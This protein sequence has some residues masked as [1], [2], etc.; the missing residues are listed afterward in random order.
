MLDIQRKILVI[1][2]NKLSRMVLEDEL[3]SSGC[4]VSLAES[5]HKGLELALSLTPDLIT[6]DL[7]L[8]DMSCLELIKRLKSSKKTESIPFVVVT[9]FEDPIQK[10]LCVSAGAVE[11]MYKPFK[12]GKLGGLIKSH[13]DSV[14]R[15]TGR[16]IL[17]VE[18]SNTIR[19]ITKHLL[20]RQGHTVIEA[21]DGAEG[22]EILDKRFAEVDMIVT[23]INMPKM[24][25]RQLV[26]KIRGDQR[27]QFIPVIVSTTIAEKGNVKLL[28]NLGADDYIVKPFSTEEFIARIHSHLRVKSLYEDLGKA[29]RGLT[30]FNETLEKRVEERTIELKEAN[31]GAIY[32]L[33]TAAEAKDDDTGF[34]V[35]RIQY[36]S[37]ALALKLGM[38]PAEADEIGYSSIMHD[39]GKISIPDEILKKP[40]K[41]TTEE[42]E[43]IKTHASQGEKILSEKNFFSTARKIARSHHEKWSGKGY[44][45][46]LSKEN[47]P[48]PA[49]IVAVAD[50]FDALTSKRPYKE[51]WSLEKAIEE[52]ENSLG[53]HFDPVIVKAWLELWKES[54]IERIHKQW[55]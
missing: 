34:H 7:I 25:G 48:L 53:S 26:E 40:G 20:E 39:V 10:E 2:N 44:P 12:Q 51:P 11:V 55:K 28:L 9:G 27:S 31:L 41:L 46:G 3:K 42:F 33:A 36:Y 6:V 35:R 45:D 29:N 21:A 13:L 16:L 38:H 22:W 54:E 14:K 17:V 32:S 50:V 23:D 24:D 52:I 19:A 8:E 49:R 43:I 18:D 30:E 47:I 1:D 4:R 5:A 15:K 37:Q